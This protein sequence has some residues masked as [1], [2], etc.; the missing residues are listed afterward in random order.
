MAKST[1]FATTVITRNLV[2]PQG[3]DGFYLDGR[4]SGPRDARGGDSTLDREDRGFFYALYSNMGPDVNQTAVRNKKHLDKIF[5]DMKIAN[6]YN[7]DYEI[8]ELADCAV[9]ISGRLTLSDSQQSPYFAGIVVKDGEMAAITSGRGCAYLYRNDL[10]YPLTKDEYP[11]SNVG[12]DGQPVQNLELYC[13]GLA[14][15]IRYSNIAQLQPDD[16]FIL[17]NKE[18]METIGHHNMLRLLEESFDQQDAACR[19]ADEMARQ[20]PGATAQ[21]LIGFVENITTLDKAGLKSLTGRMGWTQKTLGT[22]GP[23]GDMAAMSA[24]AASP[25]AAEGGAPV[26]GP[27]PTDE[28]GQPLQYQQNY[29]PIDE[30]TLGAAGDEIYAQQYESYDDRNRSNDRI[31]QGV[32]ESGMSTAKKIIIG[33]MIAVIILLAAFLGY[34]VLGGKLPGKTPKS[35]MRAPMPTGIPAV[36]NPTNQPKRSELFPEISTP[37]ES[38]K[39]AVSKDKEKSTEPRKSEKETNISESKKPESQPSESKKPATE[40]SKSTPSTQP[41]QPAQSGTKYT[42]KAGDTVWGIAQA[43]VGSGDLDTYIKAIIKANPDKATPDGENLVI[44]P[45]DVIFLPTP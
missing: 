27:T 34:L 35:T 29:E 22:A 31:L 33:V 13:A 32:E 43:H 26:V 10:L 8:N 5:E 16:C 2:T 25:V 30:A 11:L 14:G 45:G 1:R 42:V 4:I 41:T 15:T 37:D 44:Y 38:K 12:L 9:N 36:V 3:F 20:N 18:V 17:C 39:P 23:V 19:V 6:R 21:F 7:I 24:A 40:P 28:N